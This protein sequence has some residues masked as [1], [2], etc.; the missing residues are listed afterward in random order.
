MRFFF[1]TAVA[2][3]SLLPSGTRAFLPVG[4]LSHRGLPPVPLRETRWAQ[5]DQARDTTSLCRLRVV[6]ALLP[7]FI[8]CSARRHRL[9]SRSYPR[10]LRSF[11]CGRHDGRDVPGLPRVSIGQRSK[12]VPGSVGAFAVARRRRPRSTSR[13]LPSPRLSAD[14]DPGEQST[15]GF[16]LGSSPP[17]PDDMI[18]RTFLWPVFGF[19][20]SDCS[21]S[22]VLFQPPSRLKK[23]KQHDK[24]S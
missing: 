15:G 13:T 20:N 18:L 7:I 5:T 22:G 19:V 11:P 24:V 14:A 16:F 2:L 6:P 8:A 23:S 21:D 17:R 4:V 12:N 1:P 9:A 10:S 3:F